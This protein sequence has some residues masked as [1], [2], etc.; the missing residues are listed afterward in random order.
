MDPQCAADVVNRDLNAA[1][2]ILKVYTHW[3]Q[4]GTRPPHLTRPANDEGPADGQAVEAG[5]GGEVGPQG[6]TKAQRRRRVGG[7]KRPRGRGDDSDG[8]SDSDSDGT[9][10]VGPDVGGGAGACLRPCAHRT[11]WHAVGTR[12]RWPQAGPGSPP[13][14]P[15]LPPRCAWARN[16]AVAAPLAAPP[17]SAVLAAPRWLCDLCVCA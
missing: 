13:P 15:P 6:S 16:L 8:D 1:T 3:V 10:S 17:P 14:H 5:E 7:R 12:A 11:L 4:H 2:N 9:A